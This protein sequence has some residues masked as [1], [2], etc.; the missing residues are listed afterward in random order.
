VAQRGGAGAEHHRHD[1]VLRLQEPDVALQRTVHEQSR[2]HAPDVAAGPRRDLRVLATP[3][4]DLTGVGPDRRH[5]DTHHQGQHQHRP[6]LE[7]AELV[8]VPRAVGLS[9]QRVEAARHAC[10]PRLRRQS[11][12]QPEMDTNERIGDMVGDAQSPAS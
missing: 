7:D 8:A 12:N 10:L 3:R 11:V 5:R 2:D 6:L 1:D 9:A 4:E